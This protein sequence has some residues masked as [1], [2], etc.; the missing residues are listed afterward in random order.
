MARECQAIQSRQAEEA[1][2]IVRLVSGLQADHD[3]SKTEAIVHELSEAVT[4]WSSFGQD[5]P[6]FDALTDL[7]RTH[8]DLYDRDRC[9]ALYRSAI[10]DPFSSRKAGDKDDHALAWIEYARTFWRNSGWTA[11]TDRQLLEQRL[12]DY[13]IPKLAASQPRPLALEINFSV[14]E[15]DA[16]EDWT[17]LWSPDFEKS[18]RKLDKNLQ[19]RVL[20]AMLDVLE[21]PVTPRGDTVK[22]LT[23]DLKGLWR[24]RVGDYRLVYLP[25]PKVHKVLFVDVGSRGGIY[26]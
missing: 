12:L 3:A 15:P 7:Y 10:R 16:R 25:Q 13:Q 20:A 6:E 24:Y 19:G 11:R 2:R 9:L 5:R 23:E 18:V 21:Q 8:S 4:V 22:P 26:N 14:A 1:N 17:M